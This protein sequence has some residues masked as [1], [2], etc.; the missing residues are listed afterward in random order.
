[1]SG[2]P[3]TP[4]GTYGVVHVKRCGGRYVAHTRFRDADGRLRPVTATAGSL[5]GA[6][7][8][9]KQRLLHRPGYG[10]G[11]VL[12]LSSPFGDLAELWLADLALRDLAEGTKDGYRD[13][14]RLHVRPALEH[15][16]LG[17][18]TTGRMEWFLKAES[19]VS[20]SRASKSR[21]L[22]NLLFNFALRHDAIGRNPVEG[23]S[24][25]RGPK[26][27][28]RALTLAQI[29]AI[30][31]AAATWRTGRGLP[32][33]RPDGQV[34]DIIEVL[35]GTAVRVGE[36]L[37][38]RPCDLEDGPGG[39]VVSVNGTV[40]QRKGKGAL[41]QDRPKTD[42]SVRRI[43]VPEFAAV[44]LRRRLATLDSRN[45]ERTIFANRNGGV[46]S[47]YNVRRTFREFLA[48]AGLAD[49][50]ISLRWYR[51]TGATVIARGIGTEAAATFLGHSSSAI[52]E[53]HYIEP[54]RTI[55]TTPAAL[56]EHTLRPEAPDGALLTLEP[57]AEED[58][59]LAVFDD[60]TDGADGGPDDAAVA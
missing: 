23:T 13:T 56:L 43:A 2:R 39:M 11:G 30:R 50:G 48:L 52:T 9:L 25:L 4:I 41:R 5:T 24:Q 53:G 59:R 26:R 1:M 38:L 45:S 16:T 20:H 31:A 55:D 21:T 3:R 42:A 60:D 10:S 12:S 33:P 8:L 44:V 46:L 29:A 32:G 27:A 40:V 47:P 54:D 22:L 28:P 17:E 34:R 14:L 36:V 58:H 57:S 6:Q 18:L 7:A 51:R 15:Y 49:S 37:A 35:L 19:A